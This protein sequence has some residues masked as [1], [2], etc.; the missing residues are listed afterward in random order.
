MHCKESKELEE[1]V[2]SWNDEDSDDYEESDDSKVVAKNKETII[3][4]D[5]VY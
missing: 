1:G 5:D 3:Q 2:L 4:I